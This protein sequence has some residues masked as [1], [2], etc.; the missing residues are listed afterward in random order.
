METI[1]NKVKHTAPKPTST[2]EGIKYRLLSRLKLS[3]KVAV[4]KQNKQVNIGIKGIRLAMSQ[5][6]RHTSANNHTYDDMPRYKRI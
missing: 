5:L 1:E 2:L 4:N 3:K 6:R